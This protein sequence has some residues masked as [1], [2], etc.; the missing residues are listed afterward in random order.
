MAF[1]II[2][3]LFLMPHQFNPELGGFLITPARIGVMLGAFWALSA[4]LRGAVRFLWP[5]G[6]ILGMMVWTYLSLYVTMDAATAVSGTVSQIL[7]IALSYFV[8]RALI[9][10]PRD[11]RVFLIII[12]PGIGITGFIIAAESIL[13]SPFMQE[14]AFALTG[15]GRP[16]QNIFRFGLLRSLG[17]FPHPILAGVIMS[18]FL[19]I[20]VLSGL[21]G[22]PKWVGLLS[23]FS[24]IFTW[25]SAAFVALAI[26]I[27]LI[28]YNWLVEQIANLSWRIFLLAL[29]A[30]ALMI[31]ILSQSGLFRFVMR[32]AAFNQGSSYNRVLIWN[33]GTESVMNNPL[34]G[35]GFNDWV[36]PRWMR[37]SIDNYWLLLT[38]QHGFVMLFL[39]LGVVT[40]ALVKIS[41]NA[42]RLPL[43]DR[44]LLVGVGIA[45]GVYCVGIFSV[46][47]WLSAKLWFFALIGIAVSLGTMR[48]D[49]PGP[50]SSR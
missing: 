18:S 36:R 22:W 35:I 27:V 15:I 8:G 43:V 48:T 3:Y 17:P 25:S 7:D 14:A 49:Q 11:L 39:F 19:P 5:D 26:S 6:L 4:Y 46:S 37:D 9:R 50:T 44:R 30:S 13:G 45:L 21:R 33:W 10:S 47:V 31:E 38:M 23:P 41:T 34:W 20:Y 32:Y 24:G 2:F 29:F 12:A 28:A 1:A 42:T 16:P 40:Y